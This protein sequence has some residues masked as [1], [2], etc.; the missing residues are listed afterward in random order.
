MAQTK[1][2]VD[3][4]SYFRLAQNLHPLL[5]TSFGR[6][7]YTLYAHEALVRE[8]Q[9]QPRLQTKFHWFSE[10]RYLE[11]RARPLQVGR[12][13]KESIEHTFEFMWAHVQQAG[14][15]ASPVDTRILAAA[16]ELGLR[17]VT[18][19]QDLVAL[20]GMYGV[21]TMTSLELMKLM[22]DEQHI[23]IEQVRQVAAQWAYDND[24]P[25]N[26]QR[27]YLALF[28]ERPRSE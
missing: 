27:D 6:A 18:D 16:S 11:N 13:E 21:H 1:I 5:A 28:G 2:L 8:F 24:T 9:R 10:R 22:L 20:A 15:G 19:D 14:I 3:T 17:L 26:F 23:T 12:K 7:N 4:S 25:A